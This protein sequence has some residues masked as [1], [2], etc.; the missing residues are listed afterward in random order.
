MKKCLF[1][2]LTTMFIFGSTA[3]M[4]SGNLESS[5]TP[6]SAENVSNWMS[7]RDKKPSDTV[8]SATRVENGKIVRVKCADVNKIVEDAQAT[9]H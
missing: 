5:L 7:C 3:T 8:K 1:A 9:S 4:A 2:A 6:I